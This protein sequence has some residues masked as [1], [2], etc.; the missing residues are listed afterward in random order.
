MDWVD[1]IQLG[2]RF[3]YRWFGV[4]QARNQQ[5]VQMQIAGMNVIKGIPPDQY[6]GYRLNMVP[7]ITH[8]CENLY[9]PRLAPLIFEDIKSQLTLPAEL[10]NQWLQ[11]GFDLAV[12]PQDDDP[13]HMQAHQQLLQGGDP[14]G[15]VRAHIQRHM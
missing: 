12:S 10:E 7:L 13:Q 5:Q 8:L 11:Q 2:K 3:S 6:P 4:E 1:P 15:N 14:Q 9:G